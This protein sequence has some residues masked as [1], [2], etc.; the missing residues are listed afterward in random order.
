[1]KQKKITMLRDQSSEIQK[2]LLDIN[3]SMD[4]IK[5]NQ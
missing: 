4:E 3:E 1:M 2:K 5:G